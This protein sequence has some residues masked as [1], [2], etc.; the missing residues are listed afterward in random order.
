MSIAQK[1]AFVN[2][3]F[4]ST[5]CIHPAQ[6]MSPLRGLFVLVPA[7]FQLSAILKMTGV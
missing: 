3:Y 5:A 4:T 2:N 6:M 7:A 1:K